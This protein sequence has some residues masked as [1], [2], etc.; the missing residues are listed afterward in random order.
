MKDEEGSAG[1]QHAAETSLWQVL[2]RTVKQCTFGSRQI[3]LLETGDFKWKL[4]VRAVGWSDAL[5]DHVPSPSS[6]LSFVATWNWRVAVACFVPFLPVVAGLHWFC[7]PC[8]WK[9]R[10]VYGQLFNSCSSS[11]FLQEKM[12]SLR[13]RQLFPVHASMA[14]VVISGEVLSGMA[15]KIFPFLFITRNHSVWTEH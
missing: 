9:E 2:P 8:C 10:W 7:L 3:S 11:A 15:N 12:V 14:R 4:V 6:S 5:L 13:K 1:A